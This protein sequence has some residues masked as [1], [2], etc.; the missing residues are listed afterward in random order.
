[1]ELFNQYLGE[2]ISAVIAGFGGWFFTRRK[3]KAEVTT[4]EIENGSKVVDL[5][6]EALNDLPKRFEEKYVH[7]KEM[8]EKIEQLFLQ[9]EKILLQEIDYHK[10]QAALY[11]KMYDDKVREFNQYKREH[12]KK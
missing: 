6:K 12:P 10:K 3:Q 9:K 7:L 11:K 4:T 5:Y 1:M 2:I 8:G